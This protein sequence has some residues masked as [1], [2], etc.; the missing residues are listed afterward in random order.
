MKFKVS[1]LSLLGLLFIGLK[2]TKCIDW[3]WWWVLSPFWGPL[4]L[5]LVIS[6]LAGII[7]LILIQFET[8]QEK[9]V[10][11]LRSYSKKLTNNV[12]KN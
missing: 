10:R 2:L 8:P 5:I 11:L 7:K 6:I 4:A 1:F 3:S 12:D 9:I